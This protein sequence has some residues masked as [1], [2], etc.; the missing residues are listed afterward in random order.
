MGL[1]VGFVW[2]TIGMILA[3]VYFVFVYRMFRGKVRSGRRQ[4]SRL[5][6]LVHDCSSRFGG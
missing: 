5:L 4:R 1:S 3:A 2:W 6:E